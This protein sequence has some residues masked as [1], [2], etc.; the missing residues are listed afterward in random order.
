MFVT[1]WW[2][3]LRVLTGIGKWK[4][5]LNSII[6][7]YEREIG[8]GVD[9]CACLVIMMFDVALL[10]PYGRRDYRGWAR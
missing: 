5:K 3:Q 10:E 7:E 6:T 1:G 4:I 8:G 2:L 9:L